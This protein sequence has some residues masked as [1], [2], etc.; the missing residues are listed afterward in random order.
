METPPIP[1]Y[2][3][4]MRCSLK[5]CVL[6]NFA[7]FTGKHL[8]QSLFFNKVVGLRPAILL[9]KRIW[10]RCFPVTFAKFL[11]T[12]FLKNTS[13]WLVLKKKSY[14]SERSISIVLKNSE[15]VEECF[16]VSPH[17]LYITRQRLLIIKAFKSKNYLTNIFY[18]FAFFRKFIKN[19][20]I[21]NMCR[22]ELNNMRRGE[23]YV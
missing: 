2:T 22:G 21:S 7:K 10:H 13:G 18:S 23:F 16:Y 1:S 6:R 19:K 9:K 5:K 3:I 17:W 15:F 4:L 11:R 12:P 20:G 14:A 8:C